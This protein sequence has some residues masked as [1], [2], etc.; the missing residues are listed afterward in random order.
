M[1]TQKWEQTDRK[2]IAVNKNIKKILRKGE[3]NWLQK[4]VRQKEIKMKTR[5]KRKSMNKTGMWII[6]EKKEKKKVTWWD[7]S[8]VGKEMTVKREVNE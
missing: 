8:K 2:S 4:D 7:G 6:K 1:K 5:N 3:K